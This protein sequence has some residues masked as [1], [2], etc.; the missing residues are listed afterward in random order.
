MVINEQGPDPDIKERAREL[1]RQGLSVSQIAAELRLHSTSTVQDW[2]RGVPPPAWTRRPRA[3][4][5]ERAAP[6]SSARKA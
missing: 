4:D 6:G 5:A 2:V 3:K 1:R